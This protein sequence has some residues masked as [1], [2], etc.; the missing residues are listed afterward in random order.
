M[1]MKREKYSDS[2]KLKLAKT[3]TKI[4]IDKLVSLGCDLDVTEYEKKEMKGNNNSKPVL[5]AVGD[6]H[7]I[8]LV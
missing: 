5:I 4:I 8:R 2:I 6:R 3:N 1:S 7:G